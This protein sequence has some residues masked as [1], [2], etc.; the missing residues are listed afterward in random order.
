MN[1][2]YW[3]REGDGPTNIISFILKGRLFPFL[4]SQLIQVKEGERIELTNCQ[5]GGEV[6]GAMEYTSIV[7]PHRQLQ[8]NYF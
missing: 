7:L 2:R 6:L 3:V 8:Q 5:V 1:F 4:F